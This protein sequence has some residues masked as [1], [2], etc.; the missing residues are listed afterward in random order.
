MNH[1]DELILKILSAVDAIK[2]KTKFVKIL[3][4]VCKLLEKNKIESPF[5]FVPSKY[6]VYPIELENVLGNLQNENYIQISTDPVSDRQDLTI[7]KKIT[8]SQDNPISALSTQIETLV[9]AL[10]PYSSEEIIAIS[11][12]FFPETTTN[13]SIKPI[14]NKKI[15]EMFS[16][17]SQEFEKDVEQVVMPISPTNE[18]R[19]LYPQFNDMDVRVHMMKSL[20]LAEL[21]PII[22][23]IIDQS[24][25]IIAKKYPIF[26]KYNLEK[27]LEDARRR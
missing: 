24:T 16:P 14:I 6:G 7:I 25:G 9:Q 4:L 18:S 11:Y 1:R 23:D 17:L 13:S 3:H 5:Q 27:M 10:N 22:P 26:K 19:P 12:H 2:G 15:M 8:M 20:G 21:P